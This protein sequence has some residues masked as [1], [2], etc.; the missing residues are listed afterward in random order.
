VTHDGRTVQR[1]RV[2]YN[3]NGT[4]AYLQSLLP[5]GK[6]TCSYT[7]GDSGKGLENE[8]RLNWESL[9]IP[10]VRLLAEAACT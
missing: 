1:F 6:T 3:K 10:P 5:S 9:A 2:D 7:Y 8:R 4:D